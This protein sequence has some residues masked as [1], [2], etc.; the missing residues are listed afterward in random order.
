MAP[1]PNPAQMR[2]PHP[3]SS[4][5]LHES[6]ERAE[7]ESVQLR[8][9][10]LRWKMLARQHESRLKEIE[11]STTWRLLGVLRIL[12]ELK[13]RWKLLLLVAIVALVSLPFWPLLV[14]LVCFAGGRH[15]VWQMLWK[16]T[17]LRDLMGFVRQR[18]LD[19]LGGTNNDGDEIK[20]LIYHRP[21]ADDAGAAG[22]ASSALNPAISEKTSER[23]HWMLL[24]QLCPQRRLL[25]QGF[26]L[27][28]NALL[29]DEEA[30]ELLSLSHGEISLLRISSASLRSSASRG[31]GTQ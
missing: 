7:S 6:L 29:R 11:A 15:L 12:P 18:L 23:R 2:T 3:S 27:T 16:I 19:H 10:V 5:D 13:H 20:P 26:G 8:R 1:Q 9:E 31:A 21:V 17:P 4:S 28:R 24:Q 22:A 30:P 25:L 14:I